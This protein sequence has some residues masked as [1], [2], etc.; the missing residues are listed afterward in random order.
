MEEKDV[1][2]SAGKKKTIFDTEEGGLAEILWP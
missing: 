2:S 1:F